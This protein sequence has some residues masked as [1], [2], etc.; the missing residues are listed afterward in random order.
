MT[1]LLTIIALRILICTAAH[2]QSTTP[3]Q[4]TSN[5]NIM[6]FTASP[7]PEL[8]LAPSANT[9]NPVTGLLVISNGKTDR[10]ALRYN[11]TNDA[12]EMVLLDPADTLGGFG[13]W[14]TGAT[15]APTKIA[16]LDHAG[17][18]TVSG[19]V[20]AQGGVTLGPTNPAPS[21]AVC[22]TNIPL[23]GNLNSTF[24]KGKCGCS[25]TLQA[26]AVSN[27]SSCQVTADRGSCTGTSTSAGPI[28]W[29]GPNTSTA[30][31]CCVCR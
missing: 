22:M 19:N 24:A 16:S 9:T 1:K 26:T 3:I 18:L 30:A 11:Q 25:T 13:F 21:F 31:A 12:L 6:T 7:S 8:R 2:A 27:G 14:V 20:L 29:G 17:N 28:G 15:G 4:G 23:D 10:A 5:G